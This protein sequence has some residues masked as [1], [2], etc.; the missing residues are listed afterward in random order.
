MKSDIEKENEMRL[1]IINQA[2]KLFKKYGLKKTTMDEIAFECGK[3]KSTLYH[4]YNNKEQIFE[5][6]IKKE[7]LNV[8]KVVKIQVDRQNGIANKV[9]TYFVTFHKIISNYYNL[10]RIIKSDL[11]RYKPSENMYME[12]MNYEIDYL[13]V[14]LKNAIK[15][16]E[17]KLI[18]GKNIKWFAETLIVSFIG[19]VHHAIIKNEDI[20]EDK[21]QQT[22]KFLIPRIIS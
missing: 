3:A 7:M 18:D 2:Q 13:S 8:R 14:I 19:M 1:T 10:E 9:I 11:Q 15:N 22:A 6:V 20:S 12:F 16:N 17:L 21:F 4:Y 5:D